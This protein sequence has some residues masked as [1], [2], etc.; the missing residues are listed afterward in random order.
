MMSPA[1]K[2]ENQEHHRKLVAAEER[3]EAR[4]RQ[5]Q[6]EDDEA[7]EINLYDLQAK[8]DALQA[9]YD[10]LEKLEKLEKPVPV[11]AMVHAGDIEQNV[12][13]FCR[14][15]TGPGEI[16]QEDIL[17]L[18]RD[19]ADMEDVYES[20]M[21]CW[22]LGAAYDP[23]GAPDEDAPVWTPREAPPAWFGEV[24]VE[25]GIGSFSTPEGFVV[26]EFIS[27]YEHEC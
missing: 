8:Y 2:R 26:T 13:K 11:V 4:K 14:I 6:Y 24:E 16:T 22:L 3:R 5:K 27:M 17:E 9:K 20:R 1:E 25:G 21:R 12:I 18:R 23:D 10:A 19:P 15:G 7:L